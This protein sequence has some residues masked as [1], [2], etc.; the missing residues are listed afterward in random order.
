MDIQKRMEECM[1]SVYCE[2]IRYMRQQLEIVEW[3]DHR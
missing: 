2:N 3:G 1:W